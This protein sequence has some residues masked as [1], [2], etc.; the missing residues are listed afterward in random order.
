MDNYLF[1]D[2][3]FL[4]GAA[5]ML[6]LGGAFDEFD[7]SLTPAQADELAM[8]RDWNAVGADLIGAMGEAEQDSDAARQ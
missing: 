1:A 7:G 6:D 5:R 2:P 4:S 3:S 8:R